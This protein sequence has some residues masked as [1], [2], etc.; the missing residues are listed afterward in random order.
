MPA[1]VKNDPSTYRKR[2]V[3]APKVRSVPDKAAAALMFTAPMGPGFYVDLRPA[4]QPKPRVTPAG[5]K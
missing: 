1:K 5:R 2:E 3:S 4:A